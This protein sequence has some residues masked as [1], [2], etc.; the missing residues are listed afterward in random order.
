M[1]AGDGLEAESY[2]KMGVVVVAADLFPLSGDLL[3]DLERPLL[4][5]AKISSIF[6]LGDETRTHGS[7]APAP[8]SLSRPHAAPP[9]V[10]IAI[11]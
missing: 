5:H 3:R 6:E 11:R 10:C 7:G 4:T 9:E 8:S 2:N 1:L